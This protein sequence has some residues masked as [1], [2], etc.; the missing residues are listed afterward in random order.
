TV[1]LSCFKVCRTMAN[2]VY[3]YPSGAGCCSADRLKISKMQVVV[4]PD[5]TGP[6]IRRPNASD[7]MNAAQ[8]GGAVNSMDGMLRVLFGGYVDYLGGS[9]L[10]DL[11]LGVRTHVDGD[12]EALTAPICLHGGLFQPTNAGQELG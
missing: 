4:L 6:A 2:R 9:L 12:G 1:S 5:P 8:V 3:R 7:F 10:F 11:Q